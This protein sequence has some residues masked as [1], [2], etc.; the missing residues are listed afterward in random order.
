MNEI[1]LCVIILNLDQW[2]IYVAFLALVDILFWNWFG[3]FGRGPCEELLC[4]KTKSAMWEEDLRSA[5]GNKKKSAVRNKKTISAIRNKKKSVV[6][7]KKIRSSYE[8]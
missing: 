4:E 3:N 2:I 7:K 1:Q 5:M 6:G 8:K